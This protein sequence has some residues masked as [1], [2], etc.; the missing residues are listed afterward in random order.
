MG[1]KL[2][3]HGNIIYTL[4]RK[5]TRRKNLFLFWLFETGFL[6]VAGIKGVC[7]HHLAP[8][9]PNMFLVYNKKNHETRHI[10]KR[11]HKYNKKW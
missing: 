11:Q 2:T 3:A 8:P 1:C 4:L 10:F 7:H 9:P 6:Y 5:R